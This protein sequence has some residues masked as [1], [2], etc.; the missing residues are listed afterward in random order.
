LRRERGRMQLSIDRMEMADRVVAQS[1]LATDALRMR[2]A[3]DLAWAYSFAGKNP[4]V[5]CRV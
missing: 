3:A 5:S 4:E 2:M 1:P